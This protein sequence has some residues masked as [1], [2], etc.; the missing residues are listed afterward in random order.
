MNITDIDFNGVFGS[1]VNTYFIVDHR[2]EFELM[3]YKTS[4]SG[5]E[6]DGQY[7]TKI[8]AS[9]RLLVVT[10]LIHADYIAYLD[11]DDKIVLYIYKQI[12]EIKLSEVLNGINKLWA[13]LKKLEG[14]ENKEVT[15]A[16]SNAVTEQLA[17]DEAVKKT[18]LR[19]EGLVDLNHMQCDI[20]GSDRF[21]DFV[22]CND[23]KTIEAQCANC[24]TIYRMVPSKYYMVHS[25]TTFNDNTKNQIDPNLLL[26]RSI[27]G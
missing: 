1:V 16:E 20:C 13:H 11:E 21:N 3:V 25:R 2:A 18:L 27:G 9:S 15:S 24:Y 4:F 19:D 5:V 14:S 26:G 6:T 17:Y 23:G 12:P 8:D 7:S 22:V 10:N